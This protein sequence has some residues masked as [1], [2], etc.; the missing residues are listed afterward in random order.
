MARLALSIVGAGVGFLA[1]GGNPMGARIGFTAGSML[2][3]FLES[4]RTQRVTIPG[5]RLG[6]AQ[7]QTSQEGVP[8][9]VGWGLF[10]VSGNI[11]QIGPLNEITESTTTTSGGGGG[12]GGGGGGGKVETTTESTRRL[13]TFAVG[14]GR[15]SIGPILRILRIWEYDKLVYDVRAVPAIPVEDTNAFAL[16]IRIHLGNEDQLPDPDLEAITGVGET[17]HYRGL[18]HVVFLEKDITDF[19]S[20]IPQY[21]FEVEAGGVE[22]FTSQPYPVEEVES[23]DSYATMVGGALIGTLATEEL[24]ILS[25]DVVDGELEVRLVEYEHVA[26]EELEILSMDV[27]DGELTLPLVAY[28]HVAP[29]ELEIL[30]MDVVDGELEVRLIE[31]TDPDNPSIDSLGADVP[32]GDLT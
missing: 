21:R 12:K 4:R 24:E 23:L 16:G 20:V 1:S 2:G 7:V 17:P 14:V 18:P 28:E 32:E 31:Y 22:F 13:R 19:G 30:S 25:M 10:H 9:P 26:P 5:P 11:L 27:V 3:G 15:S 29:E 8:I 6:D